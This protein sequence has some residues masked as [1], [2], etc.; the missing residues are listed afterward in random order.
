MSC[1]QVSEALSD[2]GELGCEK[3]KMY[4]GKWV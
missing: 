3:N 4:E 2:E 1:L